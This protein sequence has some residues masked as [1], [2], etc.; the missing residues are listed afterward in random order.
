MIIGRGRQTEEGEKG[1]RGRRRSGPL[2]ARSR[3]ACFGWSGFRNRGGEGEKERKKG[4]E[5]RN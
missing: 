5:G 3:M 2:A 1:K 4:R